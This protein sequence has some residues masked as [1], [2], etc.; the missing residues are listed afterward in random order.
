MI[1]DENFKSKTVQ[2]LLG[3]QRWRL[4]EERLFQVHGVGLHHMQQC[5]AANIDQ[6]CQYKYKIQIN[7]LAQT[8]VTSNSG[9]GQYLTIT[10]CV[11]S[12]N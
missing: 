3:G 11:G 4:E 1:K 9:G 6:I 12:G 5:F 10:S 7:S 2:V 8:K